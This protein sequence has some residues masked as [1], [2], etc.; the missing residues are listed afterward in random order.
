MRFHL[1]IM[2]LSFWVIQKVL[3]YAHK[4]TCSL[5]PSYLSFGV[6]EVLDHFELR[7][8]CGVWDKDLGLFFYI[9]VSLFPQHH[10]WKI[11]SSLQGISSIFI[12]KLCVL[13]TESSLLF[14]W[15]MSL[16]CA[17][18]MT[19]LWLWFCSMNWSQVWWPPCF[20]ECCWG[21]WG[22]LHFH[23]NYKVFPPFTW[24]MSVDLWLHWTCDCLWLDNYFHN[25]DS[26]NLWT[27][28]GFSSTSVIFFS[29][30]KFS[31]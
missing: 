3:I 30:L 15:P 27:W 29:V 28:E 19:F 2:G 13:V 21:Y 25:I 12:K 22:L 10:Q 1:L 8:F 31:L 20:S 23:M 18:N 26:S 14:H 24:R 11:L 5:F 16:F 9:Q 17:S 7:F 4:L 6:F